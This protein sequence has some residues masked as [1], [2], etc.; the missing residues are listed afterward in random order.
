MAETEGAGATNMD[1]P[2]MGTKDG[3]ITVCIVCA[4]VRI[5]EIGA[6]SFRLAIDAEI[7][8]ADKVR[9]Q[10]ELG[11]WLD[12]VRPAV[13]IFHSRPADLDVPQ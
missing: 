11:A 3:D 10:R 8:D 2:N 6:T 7:A 13:W 4:A 9:R 1:Q 5:F 12:R